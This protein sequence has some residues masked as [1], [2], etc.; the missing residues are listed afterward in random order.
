[1]IVKALLK[2]DNIEIFKD[3]NAIR[4]EI[5]GVITEELMMEEEIDHKVRGIL[6]SYKKKLMEGSREWEI[7][8]QKTYE[9]EMNKKKR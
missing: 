1:M 8:Y 9:E 6:S 7:L 4:L 3:N 2:D 5:V